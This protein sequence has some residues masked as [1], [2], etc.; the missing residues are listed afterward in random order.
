MPEANVL[1]RVGND[2]G[3]HA[4]TN[5]DVDGYYAYHFWTGPYADKFYVQVYKNGVP[6]SMQYWWETSGGC[7]SPYAIQYIRVDWR[8]Y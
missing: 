6:Q 3:W 8:H 1:M 4:D 2:D 5:T 7:D